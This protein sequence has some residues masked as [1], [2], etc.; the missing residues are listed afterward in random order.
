M[1]E[2]R[3]K[4]CTGVRTPEWDRL[5]QRI[6]AEVVHE[7][8]AGHGGCPEPPQSSEAPSTRRPASD[9]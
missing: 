9:D 7:V 3:S 8:S 1:I 2:V 4:W 6:L 5:W